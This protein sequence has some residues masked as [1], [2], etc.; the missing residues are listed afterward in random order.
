MATRDTRDRGNAR[1]FIRENYGGIRGN[2]APP[3][4][5]SLNKTS[6][7]DLLGRRCSAFVYCLRDAA[8]VEKDRHSPGDVAQS[9]FRLGAKTGRR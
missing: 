4:E 3:R 2:L 6:G 8:G 5:D 9:N 1:D 7:D